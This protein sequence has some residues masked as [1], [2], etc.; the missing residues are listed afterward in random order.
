MIQ[1]FTHVQYFT[2][3]LKDF[4]PHP[5]SLLCLPH[6]LKG[7]AHCTVLFLLKNPVHK[8]D[9]WF[10]NNSH[11]LKINEGRGWDGGWWG[12]QGK[13]VGR[14]WEVE[15]CILSF[16]HAS[17][18]G[19]GRSSSSNPGWPSISARHLESEFVIKNFSFHIQWS[20]RRKKKRKESYATMGRDE[21]RERKKPISC[22]ASP[23]F[24]SLLP[25][26]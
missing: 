17:G 23:I 4:S 2:I 10:K 22:V 7:F 16:H 24:L 26:Q 21:S 20:Q 18:R 13:E 1:D 11:N 6:I 3:C 14:G 19:G 9:K 8:Q 25:P 15:T 12:G 5:S